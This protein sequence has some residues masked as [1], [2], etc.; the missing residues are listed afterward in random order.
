MADTMTPPAPAIPAVRKPRRWL[1]RFTVLLVALLLLGWFAPT[2][3]VKTG[4]LNSAVA[5]A[6]A[7]L[8]GSLSVGSASLGWFSPVVLHDVKLT[9]AKGQTVLTAPT[10]ESSRSLLSL[11]RSQADLGT[12]TIDGPQVD[13]VAEKQTTNLE[14]L[15]ANYL[16]DTTPST[17]PRPAVTVKVTNGTLNVRDADKNQSWTVKAMDVSAA[18]P[19]GEEPIKV[20]L[21]GHYED[22]LPGV[23]DAE[24]SAG[25]T[26]GLKL[27]AT[28]LPLDLVAVFARRGEPGL[29]AAGRLNADLETTVATSPQLTAKVAGTVFVSDLELGS[30]RLG[31]E[32][33]KLKTVNFPCRIET[34]AA[35]IQIEKA[36][37]TCDIGKASL[38]GLFDPN[39]P[40]D[41]WLDQAGVSASA[42]LDVARLVAMF[43]KL[44]RLRE[45]TALTEG[46]VTAKLTSQTGANGV[47]WDGQLG[48]SALRGVRDGKPLAWEQPLTL[49]FAGRLTKE[50]MPVFDRLD[51]KAE[52]ATV[53]GK[54]TVDN[55]TL[56]ADASL[57]QLTRRLG[58]F[59]DLTGLQLGGTAKLSLVTQTR[60]DVS[61]VNG[62]L[63]LTNLDFSDGARRFQEPDLTATFNADGAFFNATATRLD[64][65]NVK[66]TAGQETAE[67]LLLEPIA[68]LK[69]AQNGK[70][71]AKIT[72]DLERWVG[73]VS[74]FVSIPKSLRIGG[75]GTIAGN[76]TINA[77]TLALDKVTADLRDAKFTGYGVKLDES[78]LVISP[79]TGTVYRNTGLIEFPI[80]VLQT[81]TVAAAVKPMK[82][83]PQ[84]DGSYGIELTADLNAN[85][86]RLQQV[87]Q[88][89]TDPKLSDRID[90]TV[91]NGHVEVKTV[92]NSYAFDA[93]LPVQKFS[94]GHP[95]KP[96]WAEEKVSIV[97][98]GAY[99]IVA[100]NLQLERALVQRP[101][102]LKVDATG[103]INQA[104]TVSDL[105]ISGKL[106]YDLAT[107]E[108]QLKK[109]L[110]QSFQINGKDTRDF[111]A[112]GK[113]SAGVEGLAVNTT[114]VKQA[115]PFGD[116]NGNASLAWQSLKAYGFDVG[117]SQLSAKLDKGVMTIDPLEANFGQ[118]GKVRLEPTVRFAPTGNELTLAKG[119]VIDKAKLTPAACAD[120]LGYVL[121]AFARSTETQGTISLDLEENRIPLANPETGSMKGKLTLH[122]VQ[123]GP[124]P[125]ITEIATMLGAKNTT[126][127][128]NRDNKPQEVPIKFE[129]GWVHHENLTL[130]AK[131]IT[132]IT[133]GA[134]SVNGELNMVADVP[135]PDNA[136][137]G[138]LKNNPKIREALAGKR[139]KVPVR[140]TI[141]KPQLDPKAF[142]V[143]VKQLTEDV[144][145]DVMKD[146]GKGALG[147]LLDKIPLPQPKKP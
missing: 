80:L 10:V 39:Q 44:F 25:V 78:Q 64:R 81:P 115:S 132:I 67:V 49:S 23:I 116:L 77:E 13:I 105:D 76:V 46:R 108:P 145:K 143:A 79:T 11:A 96:T 40:P 19:P 135:L 38:S 125:V 30:P 142:Q 53:T 121:P 6:T 7:K 144:T 85:L 122:E 69:A 41:R 87:L 98:K 55:F 70:A 33:F 131:N 93:T 56:T 113:L 58:D 110:G 126:F 14:E 141:G 1:R 42:D 71:D 68:D 43:P 146:V 100:D 120:A 136:I 74:S 36:D 17:G 99:D 82:L 3:L 52:F 26:L 29:T 2:I 88:L 92:G 4:L 75:R 63:K 50:K 147:G 48:A 139:I 118:T 24:V 20:Q 12:F 32:Q 94:L 27:K 112:T 124:G 134:V 62:T 101:D 60:N 18:V 140:G 51:A 8:N 123:I 103:R 47:T 59:I 111:R 107:L 28:N 5:K 106:T 109:F 83:V 84:P 128:L 127:S 91:V 102:G 114:P 37:L 9:D 137:G 34:T 97:A 66:V 130:S 119:K 65:G 22:A 90:G 45:G 95:Q 117:Q 72:G 15:V 61:N 73:R 31:G 129:N 104:T 138:L 86:A 89:Q 57:D 35:G 21:S 133:S 16:N 54:G